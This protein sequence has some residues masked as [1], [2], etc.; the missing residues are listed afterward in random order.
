MRYSVPRFAVSVCM[1]L[2]PFGVNANTPLSNWFV[3][4]DTAVNNGFEIAYA[5][6]PY[7][8]R[9]PHASYRISNLDNAAFGILLVLM[10]TTRATRRPR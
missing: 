7:V 8:F 5:S 9:F 6:R 10:A 3:L 4:N 2:V 1:L